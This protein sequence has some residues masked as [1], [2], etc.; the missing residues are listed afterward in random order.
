MN[1]PTID[2]LAK[3]VDDL[4]TE[5]ETDR[6][7]AHLEDCP[8]CREAVEAFL[9]EQ[10]FM[11]ETFQ[12]PG[13][14]D[15]FAAKIVDQ[16]EP[17]ERQV[18]KR[19]APWKKL[20]LSAAGVVLAVGLSAALSPSFAQ[21][22]G[23][24]FN[25]EQADD[26]L[27]LAM[28]AGLAE[29]VD[30]A[31]E[32]QGI[33]LKVEDVMADS[34]RITL[35]YQ[36]LKN[37]KPKNAY[38][39]EDGTPNR[40]IAI[41]QNG[42]ELDQLGYSWWDGGDYGV[43]ELSLRGYEDIDQL[44]I[45]FDVTELRGEKGNWQLDVPVDL[46]EKRQ[47]TQT[48]PLKGASFDTDGVAIELQKMQMAPS[49][50][51]LFYET[52]FTEEE[53]AR[54]EKAGE[55]FKQRFGA[56]PVESLMR[57]F[58]PEIAYHLEDES[59]AELYS[60]NRW[61]TEEGYVSDA[62]MLQGTGENLET[63]GNLKWVNSF[64]PQ[65]EQPDMTFVLDGVY[66]TEPANF[67]ITFNPKELRKE[68]FSFEFEGNQM[69]VVHAKNETD[70]FFK[71]SVVPVR[72]V[73]TFVVEMEGKREKDAGELGIW[74]LEDGEGNVYSSGPSGSI[75]NEDIGF[76]LD[77]P[78]LEKVPEELTL[79]LFSAKHYVPVKEPWKVPLY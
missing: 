18:R 9:G 41:D 42:N 49:S 72:R 68:P 67:S 53:R 30:L 78:A 75:S 29:R 36:V 45:R 56:E 76:T 32:D 46:S 39:E 12:T 51:E 40:V 3:Y 34:S 54:I 61:D 33:T 47:L 70:Y 13:L 16:L 24:F 15:D 4:L 22:I 31:V 60:W 1:C 74:L 62:G 20:M 59:G 73:K 50:T 44:T 58:D 17:Y 79:H 35:S 5:R 52:S 48:R 25:T 37:G 21:L 63:I 10:H 14:P 71:K 55:E 77:F 38:I 26:G 43:Y 27:R 19:K 7:Q 66:K 28:E 57:T 2:E 8:H 64:V 6:V 69:K 11:V 23:G 65:K